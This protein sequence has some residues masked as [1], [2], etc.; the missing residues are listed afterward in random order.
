MIL[1]RYFCSARFVLEPDGTYKALQYSYVRYVERMVELVP[2]GALPAIRCRA[3]E[4]PLHAGMGG[5][6]ASGAWHCAPSSGRAY[7][8]FGNIQAGV[9]P[10]PPIISP[11][12]PATACCLAAPACFRVGP[13][14]EAHASHPPPH[15][16][17]RPCRPCQW[18]SALHST[19][20]CQW[21]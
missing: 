2:T 15:S 19:C 14:E 5:R 13:T 1:L 17:C 4:R 8:H 20:N 18:P 6:A 10:M 7:A 9:H 16:A 12:G 21:S 11:T 3:N